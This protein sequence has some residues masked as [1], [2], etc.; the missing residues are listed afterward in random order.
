[1]KRA[2]KLVAVVA[3]LA[4]MFVVGWGVAK[5]GV[6]QAVD[7]ASLSSLEQGFTRTIRGSHPRSAASRPSYST[8][9]TEGV[10]LAR[11]ASVVSARRT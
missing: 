7:P 6:G 5:T 11:S 2:L 8:R 9:G 3:A 4:L 1:M 10:I